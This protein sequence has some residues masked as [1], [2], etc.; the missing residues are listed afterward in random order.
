MTDTLYRVELL[1]LKSWRSNGVVFRQGRP[2]F[3][4]EMDAEKYKADGYFRVTKLQSKEV[5][6]DKIAKGAKPDKPAL[7]P[8]LRATIKQDN[9][10]NA[11]D[12]VK[13]EE[14]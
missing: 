13:S 11:R 6:E 2:H 12:S 14:K 5:E 1:G 7:K 9:K 4:S 8:R 10:A 3:M